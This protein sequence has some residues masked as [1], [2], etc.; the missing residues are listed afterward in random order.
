MQIQRWFLEKSKGFCLAVWFSG[1][2]LCGGAFVLF[3]QRFM[4]GGW[5]VVEPADAP[6][7]VMCKFGANGLGPLWVGRFFSVRW[8]AYYG[9]KL[10]D[11]LLA[12]ESGRQKFFRVQI[13]PG[14]SE[15]QTVRA[16]KGHPALDA[17]GEWTCKGAAFYPDTYCVAWKTKVSVI[18]RMAERRLRSECLKLWK[19]R[20]P[21]LKD[22]TPDEV[23][24]LSSLVEKETFV[25]EEYPLI[26]KVILLRLHN[27]QRLC[28]DA[29]VKF[30]LEQAGVV[31]QKFMI[32]DLFA[33]SKYNTYRNSGLP[34]GPICNPSYRVLS[35]VFAVESLGQYTHYVWNPRKRRH[36]FTSSFEQHIQA[37]ALCK[38][39]YLK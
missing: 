26:T 9:G 1:V 34:P 6:Y 4:T 24:V 2:L 21:L 29:T 22:F 12:V 30:A 39:M 13:L 17:S 18:L 15:R 10:S 16:L 31:K 8:G 11:I 25:S 19:R 7:D 28:I 37:K 36:E 20:G 3:Q 5:F 23:L 14:W 35:A 33:K 38:K 27:K 32:K